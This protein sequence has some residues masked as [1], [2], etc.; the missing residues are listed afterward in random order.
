MNVLNN[1]K[2]GVKLTGSFL[3]V[4]FLIV[5]V[6]VVGYTNMQAIMVGMDT[7]YNGRTLPIQ[8]LGAEAT[9]LY[10]LRGDLYKSMAVPVQRDEAFTAIQADITALEQQEKL[11]EASSMAGDEKAEAANFRATWATYKNDAAAAMDST[12]AGDTASVQQSLINNC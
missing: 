1:L 4:A 11:Y 7:L 9:V 2:I 3:L 10:T 6:A 12:K 8:Q 5:V